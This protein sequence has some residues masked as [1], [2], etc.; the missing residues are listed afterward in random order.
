[1]TT[2]PVRH[3]HVDRHGPGIDLE[4]EAY[5]FDRVGPHD[6]RCDLAEVDAEIDAVVEG[7]LR[8]G[9]VEQ[10]QRLDPAREAIERLFCWI[11][12]QIACLKANEGRDHLQIVLHAM[13]QFAKKDV[14]ILDLLFELILIRCD[15]VA[16]VCQR[17]E[18]IGWFVHFVENDIG[19]GVNRD[20]L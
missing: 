2:R 3:R 9:A 7:A 16:D 8:H 12:A 6:G 17:Q 18:A 4:I 14:L 15:A 11:A 1:M 20:S 19:P 10:R 13:L 5:A